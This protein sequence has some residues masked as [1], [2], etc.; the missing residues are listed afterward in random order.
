MKN[1]PVDILSIC[2]KKDDCTEKKG[3]NR[4]GKNNAPCHHTFCID[5]DLDT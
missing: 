1:T 2:S 5:H 4:Q 3:L